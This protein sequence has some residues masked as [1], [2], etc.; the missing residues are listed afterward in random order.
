M[1]QS[2]VIPALQPHFIYHQ[3]NVSILTEVSWVYTY[4]AT[5]Y[6]YDLLLLLQ[7]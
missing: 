3:D 4:L 7:S 1:V 2:Q 5:R 6:I